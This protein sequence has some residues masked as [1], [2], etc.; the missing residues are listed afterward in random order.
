MEKINKSLNFKYIQL[1]PAYKQQLNDICAAINNGTP[2]HQLGGMRLKSHN[3]LVRFKLGSHR[4]IC[5]FSDN[6]L[7][8]ITVIPRKSLE[9]FLKR[10]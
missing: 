2:F 7:H 6:L 9:L 1:K 8:P 10:R 5:E 4:L 3:N